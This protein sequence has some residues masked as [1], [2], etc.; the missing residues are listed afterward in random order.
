MN[1]W[2]QEQPGGAANQG[3]VIEVKD[4]LA[5]GTAKTP[6]AKLPGRAPD[7]APPRKKISPPK[8][9]R[10]PGGAPAAPAAASAQRSA[11]SSNR[12]PSNLRQGQQ[13]QGNKPGTAP[14]AVISLL[15]RHLR[16]CVALVLRKSEGRGFSPRRRKNTYST[17]S[18]VNAHGRLSSVSI[19]MIEE[20]VAPHSAPTLNNLTRCVNMLH[21]REKI[22]K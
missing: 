12:L 13:M 17:E 19:A 18:A 11:G 10:M 21:S 8:Y 1:G 22:K 9:S 5:T 16:G 2:G 15:P 3:Y 4:T 6:K 14:V 20:P 7:G